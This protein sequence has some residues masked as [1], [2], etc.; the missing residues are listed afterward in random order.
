MIKALR[1]SLIVI[2][3]V[4][5]SAALILL[6]MNFARFNWASPWGWHGFDSPDF[7]RETANTIPYPYGG[8]MGFYTPEGDEIESFGYMDPS[9]MGGYGMVGSAGMMGGYDMMGGFTNNSLLGIEPISLVDAEAAIGSYLDIIQDDNLDI[10][11]IMVFDNHAYAQIVELDTGIGALEV[12]VDP[13]TLA[14]S[15]EPGPNMM[16]NLKYSPMSGFGEFGMMGMMGTFGSQSV[17]SLDEMMN[18]ATAQDISADL[19]LPPKEAVEVAQRYL[20]VYVPGAEADEHADP[21]YGY[22]T[23]HV[24]RDGETV[25]M[26]SVNGY[27]RQVF[28]HSWHGDLIAM[29]E[30]N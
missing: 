9:M 17:G 21:F 11:E 26:L 23:I 28:L 10:G 15:P 29:N 22:Y 16:W 7:D 14:V 27:T 4:I 3:V 18:G 2:G 6:G 25:G 20:N 13:V 8:M 5:A 1:T 30:E 24:L 19:P 12:L